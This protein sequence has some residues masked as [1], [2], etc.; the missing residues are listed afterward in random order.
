MADICSA[1]GYLGASGH[2]HAQML[3]A[4]LAAPMSF[5]DAT[6]AGRLMNRFSKDIEV[7][8]A[9][10][11]RTFNVFLWCFFGVVSTIGVIAAST[12]LMIIVLVPL[13]VLYWFI[14]VRG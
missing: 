10:L 5:F 14:Q 13:L 9:V 1:V 7:M 8:D 3:L 11:P 4:I 6:P 2:L 12:P